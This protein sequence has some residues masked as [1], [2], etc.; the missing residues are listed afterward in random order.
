MVPEQT[1]DFHHVL[2]FACQEKHSHVSQPRDSGHMIGGRIKIW[3]VL[4]G[5][6]IDV[7]EAGTS[8]P[9]IVDVFVS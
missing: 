2:A 9:S 5:C 8:Y 3:C 1:P 6:P 7:V 4:D